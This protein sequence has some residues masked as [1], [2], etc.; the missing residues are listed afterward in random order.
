MSLAVVFPLLMIP[1]ILLTTRF[2]KERT[3]YIAFLGTLVPFGLLITLT[4]QVEPASTTT[5]LRPWVPTAGVNLEFLVDGLSLFYGLVISG[6]GVLVSWYATLYLGREYGDHGKFYIYLMLFVT[7]MLGVVFSNNLL[8]LFTF[9]E[10]TSV[11]SFLLIGFFHS[12]EVSRKGARRALLVTASTGL[13][14]LIGMIM[15]GLAAGTYTIS[16]IIGMSLHELKGGG[17]WFAVL[18]VLVMLGAF[19]KSAQFPFFFWLPGAMVAPTPVSTYLH[20]A[21]MVKLGVFLTARLHPLF[22][23]HELWLPLV[24]SV[25]FGTMLLGAW[26]ALRSNDL[27]AIL[28]Y[29]TI[30]QLGLLCGIYGIA[31]AGDVNLD[32]LHV[33]SHVLYKGSLFMVV[34]IVDH[35]TGIRDV[36]Q[37]GGLRRKMPLAALMTAIAAAAL[38]GL[39][40]TISFISKETLLTELRPLLEAD[41][42]VGVAILGCVL[43][44]TVMLVT[45]AARIFLKVFCGKERDYPHFHAPSLGIQISPLVLVVGVLVLGIFP[46]LFNPLV[47]HL[48]VPVLHGVEAA[49]TLSLWH[50]VTVE[51]MLSGLVLVLAALL[52]WWAE[53]TEWRWTTIPRWLRFDEAFDRGADGLIVLAKRVTHYLKADNPASYLPIVI[54]FLLLAMGY[55]VVHFYATEPVDLSALEWSY[56]PLRGWIVLLATVALL[57]LILERRWS[58][59][60]VALSVAGFFTT[61]YFVLY[62]APD[63]AMTQVLV[64]S[65]SVV[66]I[67]FLLSRFPMRTQSGMRHDF[68]LEPRHI[69]RI[70]VSIGVGLLMG[71]LVFF[72]DLYR[73]ESPL[74]LQFI[75]ST[76]PLA[77]GSNAVNTILVDFRGFDTLGEITVLLTATLGALGVMMR[78]RRK[79]PSDGSQKLPLDILQ[80]RRNDK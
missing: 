56:H 43:L 65:A 29:S 6:V 35:C 28:A 24:A 62:R 63:L 10:I 76:I 4:M 5:L 77:G 51:L 75:E 70:V 44:S 60:L 38:A 55:V 69:V 61:F 59:Q 57:A 16:E 46:S 25:G 15:L 14:M 72:A 31:R 50:G 53:R 64:E 58:A 74:G 42:V 34:G 23:Q 9:W 66:M 67:L 54:I 27:K 78:Y 22:S 32:F 21:T 26:L 79:N 2:L 7:S 52:Y 36:R 45:V 37:L 3:G 73:H 11:A 8:L 41:P 17:G 13:C 49:S 19:G 30:S 47:E 1:L 71:G 20:S 18:L 12:D 40:L 33:F 39:P 80:Q 48:R 68:G